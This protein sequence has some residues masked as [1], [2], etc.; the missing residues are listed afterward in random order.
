ME[1]THHDRTRGTLRALR[2]GGRGPGRVRHD[3]GAVQAGVQGGTVPGDAGLRRSQSN[4]GGDRRC[5]RDGGADRDRSGARG[6][7]GGGRAAPALAWRL[8]LGGGP[9]NLEA[10]AVRSSPQTT[11]G[12]LAT[13]SAPKAREGVQAP[14]GTFPWRRRSTL[15][16]AE[17]A[18]KRY[19]SGVSRVAVTVRPAALR[20]SPQRWIRAVSRTCSDGPVTRFSTQ[21]RARRLTGPQPARGRRGARRFIHRIW[22]GGV[23]V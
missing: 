5:P 23:P 19:P 22:A 11:P 6:G 13:K 14:G 10:Q 2:L 20:T 3:G 4:A 16:T 7:G 9:R 12:R 1:V 17:A 21:R 8:G 15:A 18:V